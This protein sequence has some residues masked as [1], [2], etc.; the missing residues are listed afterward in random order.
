MAT[1]Y[2]DWTRGR[3][4][5]PHSR[6]TE[7]FNP[8]SFTL[9]EGGRTADLRGSVILDALRIGEAERF[10]GPDSLP[11]KHAILKDRTIE[12]IYHFVRKPYLLTLA[13]DS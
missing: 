10:G 5:L 7:R 4:N 6:A 11:E 12:F 13:T 3:S 9:D 1:P 2:D 8:V